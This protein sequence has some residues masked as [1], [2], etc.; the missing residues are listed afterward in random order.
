VKKQ[1]GLGDSLGS[2]RIGSAP[3]TKKKKREG[4]LELFGQ[5]L[6]VN[7]SAKKGRTETAYY[8][9]GEKSIDGEREDG[10]KEQVGGLGTNSNRD[11]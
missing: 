2:R 5:A 3:K 1:G 7:Q 10:I 8:K 6:W 9:G 4:Y 11:Q